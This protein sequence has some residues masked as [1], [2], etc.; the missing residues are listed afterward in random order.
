MCADQP[1]GKFSIHQIRLGRESRILHRD[2]NREGLV[3]PTVGQTGLRSQ[4]TGVRESQ[5]L[6]FRFGKN[7]RSAASVSKAILKPAIPLARVVQ[8]RSELKSVQDGA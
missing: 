1:Q 5:A 2:S 4:S 8:L 7:F 6:R 3:P